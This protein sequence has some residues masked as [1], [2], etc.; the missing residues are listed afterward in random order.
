M[1]AID[2]FMT[3]YGEAL[4]EAARLGPIAEH[5]EH[6]RKVVLAEVAA[7]IGGAVAQ[8]E[9]RAR[10]SERYAMQLAKLLLART[11]AEKAKARVTHMAARLDVWRS[12]VSTERERMKHVQ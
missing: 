3:E 4:Q 8:A 11:A 12:K 7:E 10:A 2:D 6:M 1:S 9:N 5:E